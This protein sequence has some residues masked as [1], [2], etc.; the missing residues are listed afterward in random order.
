MG[1]TQDAN[2][3]GNVNGHVKTISA[4]VQSDAD[5]SMKAKASGRERFKKNLKKIILVLTLGYVSF[6]SYSCYSLPAPFL[7]R[8]AEKKGLTPFEYG[9][10]FASYEVVRLFMSP[11]CSAIVSLSSFISKFWSPETV[12]SNTLLTFPS[13]LHSQFA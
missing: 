11:I 8:E 5:R 12:P 9:I 1:F 3:N 4:K 7:P 2:E 6:T 13:L 10:I